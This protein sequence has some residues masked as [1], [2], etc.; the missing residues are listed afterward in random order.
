MWLSRT[1][2]LS[3]GEL[4]QEKPCLLTGVLAA[5]VTLV[6]NACENCAAYAVVAVEILKRQH[7]ITGLVTKLNGTIAVNTPD[8]VLP[9]I[10]CLEGDVVF[11]RNPIDIEYVADSVGAFLGLERKLGKRSNL[12]ACVEYRNRSAAINLTGSRLTEYVETDLEGCIHRGKGSEYVRILLEAVPGFAAAHREAACI[13]AL[14]VDVVALLKL[15][16]H[17]NHFGCGAV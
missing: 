10:L 7:C 3:A 12:A 5:L 17:L 2:R 13:D 9:G 16:D 8:L 6:V 4:R 14:F 11:L 15:S 1:T